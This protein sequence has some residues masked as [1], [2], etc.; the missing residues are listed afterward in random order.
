RIGIVLLSNHIDL[1]FIL[2]LREG[3]VSGWSYLL[4]K[5][6]SDLDAVRRAIAGVADGQIVLDERLTNG[7]AAQPA[8][9]L[10]RLTPRQRD[11]MDLIAQGYSNAAIA[12]RLVI[13][14]K[15]VENHIYGLYQELNIAR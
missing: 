7:A 1:S 10:A 5:S 2:A 12:N 8:S 15:T 6:V 3:K 9:Q 13:S 4:K 11:I 14:L